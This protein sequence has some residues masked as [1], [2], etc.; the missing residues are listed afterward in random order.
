MG[1]NKN[2]K[3]V[4]PRREKS[5]RPRR[6]LTSPDKLPINAVKQSN[7]VNDVVRYPPSGRNNFANASHAKSVELTVDDQ[8]DARR[9]SGHNKRGVDVSSGQ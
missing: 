7:A 6:C 2:R 5:I 3:R 4:D 8:L 9:D 1:R